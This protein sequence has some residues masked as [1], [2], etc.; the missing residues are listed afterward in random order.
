M[1]EIERFAPDEICKIIVANGIDQQSSVDSNAA[2]EFSDAYA[3]PIEEASAKDGRNVKQIFLKM[4][5]SILE[6]KEEYQ[7]EKSVVQIRPA[8]LK[9]PE[10]KHCKIM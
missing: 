5:K 3:I 6:Q 4:V 8:R 9:K 2:K 7:V 1:Q 10:T